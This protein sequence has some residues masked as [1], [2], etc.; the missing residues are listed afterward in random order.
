MQIHAG[1]DLGQT[2]KS[3]KVDYF[4]VKY[5]ILNRSKT[6]PNTYDLRYKRLFIINLAIFHAPR[7]GSDFPILIWTAK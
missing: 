2:L 7:S 1:P 3:Q 4:H 6:Y 5:A